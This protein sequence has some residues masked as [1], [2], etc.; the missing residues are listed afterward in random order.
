MSHAARATVA[1]AKNETIPERG[2]TE[3]LLERVTCW[4]IQTENECHF[5]QTLS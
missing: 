3:R 2:Q 1:P 4:L 5:Y